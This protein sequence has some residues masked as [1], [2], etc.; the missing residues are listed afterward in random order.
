MV[1]RFGDPFASVPIVIVSTARVSIAITLRKDWFVL[2]VSFL[3]RQQDDQLSQPTDFASTRSYL[4]LVAHSKQNKT[5]ICQKYRTQKNEF[6][7]FL[8]SI[9]LPL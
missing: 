6:Y 9:F 3:S 5:Q 2:C 8:R 4:F 1:L 7:I